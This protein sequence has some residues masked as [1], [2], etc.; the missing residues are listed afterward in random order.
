M[1]KEILEKKKNNMTKTEEK[2]SCIEEK[3]AEKYN[4][5]SNYDNLFWYLKNASKIYSLYLYE[6]LLD[7]YMVKRKF[8]DI[9][10]RNYVKKIDKKEKK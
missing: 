10:Y 5:L 9:S 8:Q 7:S 1:N 3:V 4:S 6:A 2:I